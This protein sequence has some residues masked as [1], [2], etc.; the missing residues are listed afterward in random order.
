M[1]TS[2]FRE[3]WENEWNSSEEGAVRAFLIGVIEYLEDPAEGGRMVA[4]TLPDH[5]LREDGSPGRDAFLEYFANNGGNAA[6]S[7]LGGSPENGYSYSYDHPIEVLEQSERGE[8]ES[9]IFIQSGGKDLPSPV[10]LRRNANGAW[11]LFN[12][13]S[14]AT[15]VRRADSG[16]F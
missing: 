4:M 10:H 13:S 11:K 3:R 9:K 12:V 14:L 8:T 16:D 7:Y 1:D 15:G 6:K 2:E 5:Y